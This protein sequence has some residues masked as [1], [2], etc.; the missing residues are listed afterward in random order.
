MRIEK[1]FYAREIE[2]K[3]K[4]EEKTEWRGQSESHRGGKEKRNGRLVGA[5]ETSRELSEWPR[6]QRKNFNMLSLLKWKGATK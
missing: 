3:G 6:L 5:A 2:V 1:I 4:M